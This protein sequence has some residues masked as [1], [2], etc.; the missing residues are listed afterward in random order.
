MRPGLEFRY[1]FL[2]QSASANCINYGRV[3]QDIPLV[4]PVHSSVGSDKGRNNVEDL[5]T[6]AAEGV[7]ERSVESTGK[8]PLSVGRQ[9][10]G[11]D[12]LGSRAA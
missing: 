5:V 2:E 12:A 8:R 3:G 10:V 7:E 9:V 4:S 1:S 11:G 6:E